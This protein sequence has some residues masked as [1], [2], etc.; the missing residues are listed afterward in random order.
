MRSHSAHCAGPAHAGGLRTAHLR[1]P[2]PDR[3]GGHIRALRIDPDTTLTELALPA[4]DAHSVI[5]E[6]V[7]TSGAVDQA[8]YHRRALLHLHGEGQVIK[9]RESLAAW[10]WRV[11]GVARPSTLCMAPSS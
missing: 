9:L 2:A 3:P 7:G 11:P 1:I 8:V 4:V 10:P 5:R 6:H